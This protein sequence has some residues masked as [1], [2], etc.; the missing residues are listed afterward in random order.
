MLTWLTKIDQD[1]CHVY[2]RPCLEMIRLKSDDEASSVLH[3]TSLPG[4]GVGEGRGD[5]AL[6]FGVLA[7]YACMRGCEICK[8]GA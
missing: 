2:Y 7:Q 6:T 5:A 4:V 8:R 1:S 3:L